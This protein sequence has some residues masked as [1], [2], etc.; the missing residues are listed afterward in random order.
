MDDKVSL[1]TPVEELVERFP[2]AVGFL[3]RHGIRCIRCGEPLW[4]SLGELLKEDGVE[5]PHLLVNELNKHIRKE[6]VLKHQNS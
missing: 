1:D 4:Y 2:E 3:L 5:N 6:R